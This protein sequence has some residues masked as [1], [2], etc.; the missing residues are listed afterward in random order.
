MQNAECRINTEDGEKASA[1]VRSIIGT[2]QEGDY[3]FG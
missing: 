3:D 1:S 2:S